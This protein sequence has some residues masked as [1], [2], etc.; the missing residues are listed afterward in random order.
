[1][2]P[3][4]TNTIVVDHLR[5]AKYGTH[6][7]DHVLE[8]VRPHPS[9]EVYSPSWDRDKQ[10]RYFVDGLNSLDVSISSFFS[11]QLSVCSPDTAIR[12]CYLYELMRK[13]AINATFK[14]LPVHLRDPVV[15]SPKGSSQTR[16]PIKM[17]PAPAGRWVVPGGFKPLP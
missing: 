8:E 16:L 13:N 2:E 10:I 6:I 15:Y 14:E 5:N 1:M 3:F 9:G 7:D 12:C 11:E 4:E 17:Q